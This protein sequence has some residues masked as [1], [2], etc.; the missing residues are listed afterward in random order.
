MA[1]HEPEESARM[2][3]IDDLI[4]GILNNERA[5]KGRPEFT[6]HPAD[7]GGPTKYGVTQD[8]LASYLGRPVSVMEV[9]TLTLT[10]AR[11]VYRHEF[12]VR[13]G[14]ASLDEPLRTQM[15]DFGVHSHPRTAIKHLQRALGVD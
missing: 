15:V 3:M 5:P 11:E 4:D 8:A 1:R 2:S 9:A 12:I 13:P 10:V 6:D 14:F 7:K